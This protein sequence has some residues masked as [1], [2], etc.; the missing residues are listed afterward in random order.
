MDKLNEFF[1]EEYTLCY[2]KNLHGHGWECE[3]GFKSVKDVDART[4]DLHLETPIIST[5]FFPVWQVT[6][7]FIHKLDIQWNLRPRVTMRVHKP[8][9]PPKKETSVEVIKN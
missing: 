3:K 4:H 6:P 2:K 8:V 7:T 1:G 5:T 9:E